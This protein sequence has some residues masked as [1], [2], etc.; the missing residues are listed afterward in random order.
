MQKPNS[1]EMKL[2][3]PYAALI[4]I[5]TSIIGVSA[6]WAIHKHYVETVRE[7]AAALITK[8]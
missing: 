8:D 4:V 2:V 5:V 6:G 7:Q 3:V 1:I